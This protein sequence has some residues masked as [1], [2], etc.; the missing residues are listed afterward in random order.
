MYVSCAMK[1]T[2]TNTTLEVTC[3]FHNVGFDNS[4]SLKLQPLIDEE[5]K[6]CV[7]FPFAKK[8]HLFIFIH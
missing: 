4:I 5:I 8:S 6:K 1:S 7:D 2:L 3:Y